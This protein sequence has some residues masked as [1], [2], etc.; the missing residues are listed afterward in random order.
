M[1]NHRHDEAAFR[2]YV[3]R[4]DAEAR[5]VEMLSVQ[6]ILDLQ[7]CLEFLQRLTRHALTASD[8]RAAWGNADLKT[9]TSLSDLARLY[10]VG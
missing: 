4:S 9:A 10:E 3:D 8:D 5:W 2:A 6:S 1:L 7:Q